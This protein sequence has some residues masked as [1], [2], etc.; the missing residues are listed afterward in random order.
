MKQESE[1][2]AIV[3]IFRGLMFYY[4]LKEIRGFISI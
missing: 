4:K 1:A 2:G 3:D